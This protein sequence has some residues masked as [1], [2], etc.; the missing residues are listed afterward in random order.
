MPRSRLSRS[1]SIVLAQRHESVLQSL[2]P[3]RASLQRRPAC[4]PHDRLNA[5]ITASQGEI[6]IGNI[7]MVRKCRR[8]QSYNNQ[9]LPVSLLGVYPRTSLGSVILCV[10]IKIVI[11]LPTDNR[12]LPGQSNPVQGTLVPMPRSPL[13]RG[14]VNFLKRS[15]SQAPARPSPRARQGAAP[16]ACACPPQAFRKS[17]SDGA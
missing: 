1:A 11:R 15:S 2:G 16:A 12:G 8:S 5:S 10:Q 13:S 14:V 3:R 9:G 4:P 7:H 6:Q 17:S